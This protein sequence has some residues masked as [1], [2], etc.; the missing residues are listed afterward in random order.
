MFMNYGRYFFKYWWEIVKVTTKMAFGDNWRRGFILWMLTFSITLLAKNE[1]SG[2]DE[3]L[4]SAVESAV[5]STLVLMIVWLA[6]LLFAPV[7]HYGPVSTRRALLAHYENLGRFTSEFQD[8]STALTQANALE[9][10]NR[11]TDTLREAIAYIDKAELDQTWRDNLLS[12]DRLP[13]IRMSHSMQHGMM[14]LP[15]DDFNDLKCKLK[16]TIENFRHLRSE[17]HK[18]VLST[19]KSP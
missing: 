17:V 1:M 11:Y 7:K 13:T 19:Y 10:G 14:P 4:S 15:L 6:C 5:T 16:N 8:I 12:E 2:R 18:H 9:V 3:A